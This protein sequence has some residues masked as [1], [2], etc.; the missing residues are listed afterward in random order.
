MTSK[1]KLLATAGSVS[2]FMLGA[3]PAFAD[4]GTNAGVSITNEASITYSVGGAVQ[5]PPPVASDTFVVDRKVNLIITRSDTAN[6]TV[7]PGE[8]NAAVTYNVSNQ[9]N[10]TIDVLLSVEQL[11]GD[12]FDVTLNPLATRY[13]LDDGNGIFD[14]GDSVITSIN[15]LAED[16]SVVIHVVADMPGGIVEDDEAFVVLVGQAADSTTGIAFVNDIGD[17]DDPTLVQNVFADG[18][19]S[20]TEGANDGYHS[21]TDIFE[22][23]TADISVAKTSA[24]LWDPIVGSGNGTTIFPKSIPGAIVEY[25]IAVTNATGAATATSVGLSDNL[26]ALA[27]TYYATAPASGPATIPTAGVVATGTACD[28]TGTNAD[29]TGLGESGGTVSGNLGNVTG[30]STEVLIFRA[31][32]D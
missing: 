3:S 17:A 16:D 24:I 21:A 30:G 10:D 27:V 32:I 18:D 29:A 11:G 20:G 12:Q 13:Y 28:G 8:Q 14:A 15:D 31:T 9:T 25:C 1:L 7:A 5:T 23:A 22:V 6:T 4:V 2:V 26:S 19:G